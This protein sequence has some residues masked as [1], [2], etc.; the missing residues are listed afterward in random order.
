MV[1]IFQP[2]SQLF[3]DWL[4]SKGFSHHHAVLRV[5]WER[6]ASWEAFKSHKRK[7]AKKK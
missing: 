4:R 3:Y 6:K 1:S 5:Q 7:L 2:K